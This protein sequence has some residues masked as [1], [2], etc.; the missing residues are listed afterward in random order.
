[1]ID[2]PKRPGISQNTLIAAGIH[3]S[4][5]PEPGSIEI[6][7]CTNEGDFTKFRRWRLPRA[8]GPKYWQE[9]G[10]EVYV[11]YPPGCFRRNNGAQKFG[12]PLDAIFLPEGEFKTLS[13]LEIGVW[14]IGIPS[15][16]VYSRDENG[17]RR[18]LRD[19][20][21]AVSKEKPS[22]FFFLGDNDTATNFEFAR[23]AEFLA[24]AVHP[25][26]VFLPR[27]PIDKPKGID[28]CRE[29]LGDGFDVFFTEMI[30]TAIELPRKIT[31]PEIALLLLE[32]EKG[33]LKALSCLERERHFKRLVKMCG[34]A[35]TYG[36]SQATIR[37]CKL[38]REIVGLTAT[39]LKDAIQDQRAKDARER[40]TAAAA[41]SAKSESK[42]KTTTAAAEPGPQLPL[43]EM[44]EDDRYIS[45]F[46]LKLAD[47]L[48]P[49]EVFRRFDRCVVPRNDEQDRVSLAEVEPHEFRTL[50]E[51][52]CS[53]YYRRQAGD[54]VETVRHS[55]SAENARA[56]LVSRDLLEG[57]RPIHAF[58]RIVLPI[59]DLDD[60]KTLRL[61]PKG[62]DDASKVYTAQN[63]IDYPLDMNFMSAVKLFHKL[64]EEFPFLP[65]DRER[66]K[67]VLIAA[68]LTLYA[69]HLL[70]SNSLRPNFLVTA[71][72][73]GSRKTLLC[74][75]PIIAMQGLAPA[76][77]VPKDNDEMRKLI[78]GVALSG[79]SVFFLDNVKGHLNSESLE[80]LTTSPFTQF[81]V[82][83]QNK[84]I[85]VEHGLT[86]FLTGNNATSS[87]DLRRRTLIIELFMSESRPE[88]RAIKHPLDDEKLIEKRSEI[89]GALLAFVRRWDSEGRP[90]PKYV[91]Q[92]F[93]AWSV[94]VGGILEACLYDIPKP[95]PIGGSGGDRELIEM[96]KLVENLVHGTE[97]SFSELVEKAREHLLF[98]WIIGESGDLEGKE[99][100]RF[101]WLL[102]RFTDRTFTF[103][104]CS[105]AV[106]TV[107]FRLSTTTARK[108]YL[109]EP[110]YGPTIP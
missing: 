1:M 57:L 18:L 72:A 79:S 6:T 99:R 109:V 4:D 49:H 10:S 54:R 62:Y 60:K 52:Y 31:A 26:K 35:Q 93:P 74:K 41:E 103:D 9:P 68:G 69:R 36:K 98:E 12:L 97:Y 17:H 24:S 106:T 66:A 21:V 83:G 88:D 96:E 81:R 3:F 40:A 55:L 59:I 87:S 104:D 37:L 108:K 23:N 5:Y 91:N 45:E 110:V 78:S 42:Q 25:T 29:A 32:R 82:L 70:S 77:T 53:P 47:I 43:I 28:D 8:D 71:N 86:V 44:P 92:S 75:I 22:A 33:A 64:L 2:Y 101:G 46:A 89:L 84:V 61:L 65:G 51:R 11:Y 105:D 94:I 19:L 95:S 16:I 20:Q 14:A 38:S 58:N 73:E 13:L 107:R 48:A 85:D 7:Y 30:R 67:S 50:I 39:E 34:A 63:A 102:K 100:S 15:F 56:T 80:A 76:G 90:Q 27:I